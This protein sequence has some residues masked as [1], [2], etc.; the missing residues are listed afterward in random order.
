M[1]PDANNHEVTKSK[2]VKPLM[3]NFVRHT[4]KVKLYFIGVIDPYFYQ[5]GS[6]REKSS[7]EFE[8]HGADTGYQ[9]KA[10]YPVQ[11]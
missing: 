6:C 5:N 9:K 11:P 2:L 8:I 4:L 7:E 1:D 3:H 10:G